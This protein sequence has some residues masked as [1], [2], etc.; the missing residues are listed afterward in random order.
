MQVELELMEREQGQQVLDYIQD[1]CSNRDNGKLYRP[2]VLAETLVLAQ[3][4][5]EVVEI[6]FL[7]SLC[8]SAEQHQHLHSTLHL[9]LYL[10]FFSYFY[11]HHHRSHKQI[12][13]SIHHKIFLVWLLPGLVLLFFVG[14][15]YV[16][17]HRFQH[18]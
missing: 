13:C 18:Y 12:R 8:A 5:L 1:R 15:Q 17:H 3:L 16:S 9:H 4:E 14:V 10:F 6:V 2:E 7:S 11:H